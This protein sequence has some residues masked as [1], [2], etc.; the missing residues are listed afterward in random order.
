M[1]ISSMAMLD[2]FRKTGSKTRTATQLNIHQSSTQFREA[3]KQLE[4]NQLLAKK[5][6]RY[7]ITRKG[8]IQLADYYRN[9][10]KHGDSANP[11]L[12]TKPTEGEASE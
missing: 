9:K 1:P 11:N 12:T 10:R 6:N 5:D 4:K 7:R 2:A 8:V 3:W